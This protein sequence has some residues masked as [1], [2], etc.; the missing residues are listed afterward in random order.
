MAETASADNRGAVC[1]RAASE[2]YR[3]NGDNVKGQSAV[4]YRHELPAPQ[5]A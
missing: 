1:P 2:S 5:E 3:S 4:F